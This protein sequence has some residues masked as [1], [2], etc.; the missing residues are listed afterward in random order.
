MDKKGLQTRSPDER[1]REE[2]C[3]RGMRTLKD[4]SPIT[5]FAR[6]VRQT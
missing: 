5:S 4:V 2:N 1:R 6:E 3:G